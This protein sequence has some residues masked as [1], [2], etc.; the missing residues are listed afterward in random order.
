MK[1]DLPDVT[2]LFVETRAH[3]ITKRVID[4]AMSK[5]NFGDVLIYTDNRDLIP[6]EGARYLDVPD[7][8][9]KKEA[10]QFYYQTAA[11]RIDTDFALMLEWDAGVKDVSMW[12]P[13]FLNYDYIGAPWLVCAREENTLDVGNGGFTLMSKK[14]A[15]FLASAPRI[16]P[17]VTDWDLC[18]KQR[19]G[20]EKEGFRWA[21]RDVATRFSWELTPMPEKVFGF[22][23]TFTWP[24][25]LDR[26]EIITR[27]GLMTET[28]Y[29][30]SKMDP[31][32]KKAEWLREEMPKEQWAC[33]INRHPALD[34]NR[35][36]TLRQRANM[37]HIL[38]Q[39]RELYRSQ[40]QNAGLKA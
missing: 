35:N 20:L 39:R 17:V 28:P 3:K 7:F 33:Y 40:M 23:A 8:P 15:T 2:L 31:L 36:F 16:F 21:P 9:N 30:L 18:R 27:A 13:E 4:D 5:I 19:A 6:V 22:H 24:W 26:Q 32:I 38:T 29:L 14:L 1:L 34:M 12:S 37:N 10:G 11:S 25:M